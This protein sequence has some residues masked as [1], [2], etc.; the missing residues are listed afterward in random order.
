[1]PDFVIALFIIAVIISLFF[2]SL[3]I[4]K[5]FIG[6]NKSL[7]VK[8]LERNNAIAGGEYGQTDR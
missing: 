8:Y 5:I 2:G 6:R 3:G 7:Y 1:M 4:L